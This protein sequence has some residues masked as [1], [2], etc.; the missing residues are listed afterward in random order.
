MKIWIV[1]GAALTS[2]AVLEHVHAQAPRVS[3]ACRAAAESVNWTRET[4]ADPDVSPARLEQLLATLELRSGSCPTAGDVWYY[5][6][7]LE[8]QL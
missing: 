2:I 7:V 5:R 4:L 8:R 3:P 6:S 1:L